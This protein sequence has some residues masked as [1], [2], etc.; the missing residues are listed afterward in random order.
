MN[1]DNNNGS[2]DS[3]RPERT[4]FEK[5]RREMAGVEKLPREMAGVEKLRRQM[6]YLAR[7]AAAAHPFDK[8]IAAEAG[9]LV[10]I[11][12]IVLLLSPAVGADRKI[13]RLNAI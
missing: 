1:I 3:K 6:H 7:R 8:L 9:L 10:T 5:L 11:L 4:S 13:K 2:A 12:G